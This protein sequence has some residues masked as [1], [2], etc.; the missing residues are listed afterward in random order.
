MLAA[1]PR[2]YSAAIMIDGV[3]TANCRLADRDNVKLAT[4]I[5]RAATPFG[6]FGH[7]NFAFVWIS[8]TLLSTGTQMEARM[9]STS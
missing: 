5:N 9:D 6:V 1:P 7:R 8:T 4:A 2:I 3:S